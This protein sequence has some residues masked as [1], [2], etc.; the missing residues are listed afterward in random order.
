MIAVPLAPSATT[1]QGSST[2]GTMMN[3][4]STD[5]WPSLGGSPAA[6]NTSSGAD[7]DWEML[8]PGSG[9][10]AAEEQGD[11]HTIATVVVVNKP[12]P[13]CLLRKNSQ[14]APDLREL[15]DGGAEEESEAASN[16]DEDDFSSSLVMVS[17]PPSVA[18]DTTAGGSAVMVSNNNNNNNPWANKNKVSFKDAI[19]SPS[20]HAQAL[21][22]SA[23]V[24]SQTH[25]SS[26]AKTKKVKSRYVVVKPIKRCAK[27]T[28]DLL[29]LAEQ[30]EEELHG[31]GGGGGAPMGETDAM[32]YYHRKSH[33]AKGRENG[34]KLRPDEA[35]R[36]EMIV[37]KKN[38]QRQQQ[39]K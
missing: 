12:H 39:G 34:L 18:D 7:N 6:E 29:S 30:E 22:V 20:K 1:T 31:G 35:K 4:N 32:D 28:G 17:T 27:S 3:H 36:K 13:P 38:A 23:G 24:V 26:R 19:L 8:S 9:V 15:E 37:N 10:G 25:K 21:D 5:E 2:A 11:H 33:G 16:E 14:S